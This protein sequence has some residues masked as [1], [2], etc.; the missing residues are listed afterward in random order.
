MPMTEI[1]VSQTTYERIKKL[2]I[3]GDSEK[4]NSKIRFLPNGRVALQ[5]SQELRDEM[6]GDPE[7]AIL[8]MMRDMK[9]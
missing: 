2:R 4:W 7:E 5:I 3:G 8:R 1:I 6:E 9:G